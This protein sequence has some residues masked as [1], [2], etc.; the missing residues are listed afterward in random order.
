MRC[1]WCCCNKEWQFVGK[2]FVKWPIGQNTSNDTPNNSELDP[3]NQLESYYSYESYL[4]YFYLVIFVFNLFYSVKFMHQKAFLCYLLTLIF[5][6][7]VIIFFCSFKLFFYF[8]LLLLFFHWNCNLS[9]LK[10]FI[11]VFMLIYDELY[12]N[13]WIY[14]FRCSWKSCISN[15]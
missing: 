4:N 15:W 10:W 5:M 14:C 8:I 3:S 6:W 11:S 12:F 2:T 9:D 1:Y 7:T 13:E